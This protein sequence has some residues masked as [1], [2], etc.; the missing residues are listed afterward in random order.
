MMQPLTADTE[1][2]AHLKDGLETMLGRTEYRDQAETYQPN[3]I[4]N[5]A[6]VEGLKVVKD[7][8]ERHLGMLTR[9]AEGP[10]GRHI[11]KESLKHF[12]KAQER[13]IDLLN[14]MADSLAVRGERRLTPLFMNLTG[15]DRAF[16]QNAIVQMRNIT[17][18]TV[19]A[20]EDAEYTDEL[21]TQVNNAALA[22]R[23]TSLPTMIF[24]F[25]GG[26]MRPAA[27]SALIPTP[28]TEQKPRPTHLRLVV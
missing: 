19:A 12:A 16:L 3:H 7:L 21:K 15:R 10:F 8:T 9:P 24:E 1:V 28:A 23:V 2:L 14:T 22:A 4:L 20:L 5:R 11:R 13:M 17:V 18:T 6:V 25:W 27:A 26:I